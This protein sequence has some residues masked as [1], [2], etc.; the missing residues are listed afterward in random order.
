MIRPAYVDTALDEFSKG[1]KFMRL[2]VAFTR[3]TLTVPKLERL[4]AQKIA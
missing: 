2:G 3:T 4:A 1:Q